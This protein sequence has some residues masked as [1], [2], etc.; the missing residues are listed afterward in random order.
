MERPDQEEEDKAEEVPV[1]KP[2]D[3][4]M[5]E[6]RIKEYQALPNSAAKQSR[7]QIFKDSF[8]GHVDCTKLW[9]KKDN[10]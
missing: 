2:Y 9:K 10:P 6:Y 8:L 4:I 5:L 3:T 7:M 1:L